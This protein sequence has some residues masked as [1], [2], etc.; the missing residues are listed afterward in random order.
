MEI[1]L[2]GLG[3]KLRREKEGNIKAGPH[4]IEMAAAMV[5]PARNIRVRADLLRKKVSS[6]LGDKG[7]IL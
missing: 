1:K 2:A 6:V 4:L 3:D 5:V 7:E